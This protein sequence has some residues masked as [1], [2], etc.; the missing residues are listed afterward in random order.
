MAEAGGSK[1]RAGRRKRPDREG[2]VEPEDSKP[3][4]SVGVC[5]LGMALSTLQ[6]SRPDVVEHL[7]LA[8]REF[9]LATKAV[10]DARVEDTER[11]APFEKV[12][13]G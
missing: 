5:P 9:L 6:Q 7:L 13:I 8:G 12:E 4:C 11:T 2:G 1:A 10:I 3:L